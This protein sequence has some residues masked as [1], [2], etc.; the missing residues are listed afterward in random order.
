MGD[1]VL[2]E[3]LLHILYLVLFG[4]GQTNLMLGLHTGVQQRC[5]GTAYIGAYLLMDNVPLLPMTWT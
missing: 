1:S 3:N 2:E 5:W 4:G